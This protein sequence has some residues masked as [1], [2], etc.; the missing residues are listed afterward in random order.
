MSDKEQIEADKRYIATNRLLLAS[1]DEVHDNNEVLY[2]RRRKSLLNEI[3]KAEKRLER[4]LI[5]P[6]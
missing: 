6:E 2:Q 1:L 3:E 4:E 5:C